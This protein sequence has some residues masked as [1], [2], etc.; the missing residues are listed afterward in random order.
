MSKHRGILRPQTRRLVPVKREVKHYGWVPDLPDR[1]DLTYSVPRGLVARLPPR[2]D[3][4]A[5]CPTVYNQG[6]LGSCTANAIAAALEFDLMK[7][8]GDEF[9]PSR[10]FIY[11]NERVM[12]GSVNDDSGAMLRDGIKSVAKQ[13]APHEDLWPYAIAKFKTKPTK[14]AYADAARH[15]AVLYKRVQRDLAQMKGCLASGFPFVFGF[16]VYESFESSTVGKSGHTPMPKAK[17]KMVGGHAVLA[18]GYDNAKKWFIVRNSWGPAWG[19]K[20]YF[21][22]PFGYFTDE[23]LSDD[24]WTVTLVK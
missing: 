6:A 18:V 13:G 2:V 17:E 14:R 16:S 11:Y 12:E 1:R 3:L 20:G 23:N 9:V 7:Q 24:F 8:G 4:R 15:P 10:L 5:A 19:L 22:L 21:T